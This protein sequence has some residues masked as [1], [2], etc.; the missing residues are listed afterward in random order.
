MKEAVRLSHKNGEKAYEGLAL[1]RLGRVL[2]KIVE[3]Q[4]N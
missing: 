2:W 1:V 4:K 3:N